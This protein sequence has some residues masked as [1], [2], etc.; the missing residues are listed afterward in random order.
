MNATNKVKRAAWRESTLETV[1]A[2]PDEWQAKMEFL[3]AIHEEIEPK[4]ATMRLADTL[5][6]GDI[7]E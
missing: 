4:L 3:L 1:L 2:R 6:T 5:P 7:G